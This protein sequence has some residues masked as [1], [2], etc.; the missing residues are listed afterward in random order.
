MYQD[1]NYS[2]FN[3]KRDRCQDSLVSAKDEPN[4]RTIKEIELSNKLYSTM[5]HKLPLKVS[6]IPQHE[7][8]KGDLRQRKSSSIM[9]SCKWALSSVYQDLFLVDLMDAPEENL[10]FYR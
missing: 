9:Y 1:L 3:L 2:F 8:S 5:L 6:Q 4:T 10:H 7:D